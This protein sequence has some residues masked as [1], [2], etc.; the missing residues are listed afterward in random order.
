MSIKGTAHRVGAHIDTDAIIPA[1]FLVTTDPD[2]LGANCMEGL[3]AGWI[4]RVKKNDIMVAD[5]N[6]GC[7]SSREHAPISLLGA[8]IPVVVAKSFARIFYRNGFNMGLIL[9]EVGDDFE[10]LGDGDQLE[11]D[12]EKGEIKNVTTG[13]TITCAP[14]PPF[15]KG[16]LDCGGLVEYV[17]D[18]LSK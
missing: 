6:F 12:A 4:K 17:K 13:E 8:G 3:E 5:E 16:I 11:V 14:V 15:M 10:K 18:R 2:E 9:L 7:G 1:R